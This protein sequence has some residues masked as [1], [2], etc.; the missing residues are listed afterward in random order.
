M[1]SVIGRLWFPST[2][3]HTQTMAMASGTRIKQTCLLSWE[4]GSR[5]AVRIK[6]GNTREGLLHSELSL[7]DKLSPRGHRPAAHPCSST[8]SP[9]TSHRRASLPISFSRRMLRKRGPR[10]Q[11]LRMPTYQAMLREV[12]GC[13][14]Y[15]FETGPLKTLAQHRKRERST[16]LAT[17]TW[18]V[19]CVALSG[20][21]W[22][23]DTLSLGAVLQFVL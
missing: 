17:G 13:F 19:L 14:G 16:L 10:R 3:L 21:L 15:P 9:I 12:Q 11:L 20:Q 2:P 18:R 8:H 23:D 6:Q 4:A 1:G 5:L 22:R 7:R